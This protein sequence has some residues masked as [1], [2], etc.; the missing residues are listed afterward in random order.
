MARK[1]KDPSDTAPRKPRPRN[2][3]LYASSYERMI[4]AQ[5]RDAARTE[6]SADPDKRVDFRVK[7]TRGELAQLR[8]HVE[9]LQA[10]E[11]ASSMEGWLRDVVL[12]AVR[13]GWIRR[14]G[15][16]LVDGS[17]APHG[18]LRGRE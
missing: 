10:A 13:E 11:L 16:V 18:G 2:G 17:L 4:E 12:C 8:A 3:V 14:P 6:A 5:L 7:L 9:R 15:S 1:R